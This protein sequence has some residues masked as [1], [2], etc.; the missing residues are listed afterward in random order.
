VTA[1]VQVEIECEKVKWSK[2]P[3]QNLPHLY[4]FVAGVATIVHRTS[5][6]DLGAKIIQAGLNVSF[7]RGRLS[8]SFSF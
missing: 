4:C 8:Y 6:A 7:P 5:V 2:R 3:T 1:K